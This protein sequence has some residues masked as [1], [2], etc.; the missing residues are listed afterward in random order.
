MN[1]IRAELLALRGLSSAVRVLTYQHWSA[2]DSENNTI[3]EEK[4]EDGLKEG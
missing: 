3:M 4:R 2:Q 1:I